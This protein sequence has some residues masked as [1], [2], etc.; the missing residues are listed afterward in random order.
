MPDDAA[1]RELNELLALVT[2]SISDFVV[3]T[4]LEGRISHAN[5]AMLERFGY[6]LEDLRGR[7]ARLLL[8]PDNPPELVERIRRDTAAGGFTGD[9][10]N[11]TANGD[12]FWVSLRTSLV[13]REG[14]P[15]AMVALSR[16]I[17][18][19]RLMEQELRSARDLALESARLKAQFLANVSHEIRT[20]MNAIIGMNRLLLDTD[21]D[22]QQREYAAIVA[23]AAGGLLAIINEI[24]DLSHIETGKLRLVEEVFDPPAEVRDVVRLLGPAATEDGLELTADIAPMVP[25]TVL[26]D[27]GRFR[28][29]VTNLVGNAVKFTDEG[30]VEVELDAAPGEPGT[31]RLVCGVRD[32]GPG[33]ASDQLGRLFEP[34][35]Q[36]DGSAT[37][38]HGGTGLGL[39][40]VQRLVEMMGGRIEV[41]SEPGRGSMFRFDIAVRRLPSA[42]AGTADTT[43][44]GGQRVLVADD[45]PI[46]LLVASGQ[47][48]ELGLDVVTVAGGE[49]AIAAV[50]AGGVDLVLMD[51][52]MPGVDGLEATRRI[53]AA[54]GPENRVPVI[55][56]TASSDAG[57][58]DWCR[59]AGMDGLVCKPSSG[60]ELRHVLERFLTLP[61]APQRTAA[62]PARQ[63]P[64]AAPGL[65]DHDRLADLE[66]GSPGLARRLA[67]LFQAEAARSL[68][69]LQ[70]AA[71]AGDHGTLRREAHRLGGAAGNV[72]AAA[73]RRLVTEIEQSVDSGDLA[74]VP[75]LV[76]D[77]AAALVATVE[78]FAMADGG[79]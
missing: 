40:I 75:G 24:L 5:R 53:R 38:R 16:D 25:T 60:E 8:A 2:E 37:R 21:L 66:R 42:P 50:A 63:P 6:R 52:R 62:A 56:M 54:E 35:V 20:P 11:V 79:P 36:A 13:A 14:E 34:F 12:T 18:Q 10:R 78:A 47:L 29:I 55:A 27:G 32:T 43:A 74:R 7:L 15:A 59:L 70:G 3:V 58:W 4:D 39:S 76:D 22:V 45:N 33:I 68:A 30:K 9:V 67:D 28:Q 23:G 1:R 57:E 49:A 71:A 44:R 41:E 64:V 72:G 19:R 69:A 26:G 31:L 51:C 77:V 48:T 46:N 61:A 73:V 17:S 65:L